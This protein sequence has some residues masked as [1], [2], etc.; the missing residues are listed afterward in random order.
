M[1]DSDVLGLT[2]RAVGLR[3]R[4]EVVFVLYTA[5]GMGECVVGTLQ[6]LRTV[7][8]PSKGA[9]LNTPQ[10]KSVE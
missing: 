1:C 10:L 6:S 2:G 5:D 3:S 8:K 7:L 4:K 9:P